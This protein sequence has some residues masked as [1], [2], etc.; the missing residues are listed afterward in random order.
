[1][2]MGALDSHAIVAV[3]EGIQFGQRRLTDLGAALRLKAGERSR[4][5]GTHAINVKLLPHF[6]SS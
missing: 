2:H 1:M 3:G 4:A 5:I 6:P